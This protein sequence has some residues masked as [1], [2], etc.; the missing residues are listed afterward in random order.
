M[1]YYHRLGG[2]GRWGTVHMRTG[3]AASPLNCRHRGRSLIGALSALLGL[4]AVAGLVALLAGGGQRGPERPRA[5]SPLPQQLPGKAPRKAT[6]SPT[7]QTLPQ[8]GPGESKAGPAASL[9]QTIR[10][11]LNPQAPLTARRADAWR[12]AAAGT[13]EA[14]AALKRA[15][16]N[17][18]SY[19]K[20]AIG[21]ALGQCK[22]PEA[23]EMLLSLAKGRDDVAARAALR[24]LGMTGD[25]GLVEPLAEILADPGRPEDVRAEAALALGGLDCPASF[26]A[27]AAG[28][29]RFAAAEPDG[30][31]AKAILQGL[32]RLP[33]ARGEAFFKSLLDAPEANADS[34]I[35]AIEALTEAD[36]AAV[37]L[38]LKHAGGDN[39]PDARASAAWA[40]LAHAGT[41]DMAESLLALLEKEKDPFVRQRLWQTL[42]SQRKIPSERLW[43]VGMEERGPAARLVAFECLAAACNA[44]RSAEM[45][46]RFDL[47]VVPELEATALAGGKRERGLRLAA[48]KVLKLAQTP[49]AAKALD[50][51]GNIQDTLEPEA[52]EGAHTG[53]HRGPRNKA[54]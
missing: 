21:E 18:P 23:R 34:R 37:P 2:R 43:R 25:K 19:L 28:H 22:D 20:A 9:D 35:A 14:L 45:A 36:D 42:R 38:L 49:G 1:L 13:P 40:L 33:F 17:G 29:T 44:A 32:A 39:D 31:L 50:A 24:G 5:A 12:L 6:E 41:T 51:I 16:A 52:D 46:E 10:R 15:L 53:A 26:Q 4:V 8:P 54:K 48:I 47:A 27:L 11:I 30:F 7:K 3:V